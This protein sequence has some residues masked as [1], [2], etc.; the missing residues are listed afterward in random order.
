MGFIYFIGNGIKLF[1]VNMIEYK[2]KVF[3]SRTEWYLDGKRHREG[4]L[5]AIEYDN[6]TKSWWKNGLRHR[7]D[8]PAVEDSGGKAWWV[9]GLLHRKDGCAVVWENGYKA[10]YLKGV[11]YTEEEFNEKVAIE[12]KPKVIMDLLDEINWVQAS[13]SQTLSENFIRTFKDK[14][15]WDNISCQQQHLSEDFIR[16]FQDKVNW[17]YVSAYQT[18]SEEFIR[19]FQDK[20]NWVNISEYQTLSEDFIEEFQNKVYWQYIKWYQKDLSKGFNKKFN[21]GRF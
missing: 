19:E 8:G 10:W 3:D 13:C 20:V 16:E 12:N 14:V 21:L 5:P 4:D 11:Y 1:G 9:D 17:M 15:D 7:D 18:L 2:V 6:G